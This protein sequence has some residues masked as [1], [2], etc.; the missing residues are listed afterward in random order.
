MH[1]FASRLRGFSRECSSTA[2]LAR[3]AK[4]ITVSV[5]VRGTLE[6]AVA[7]DALDT[8]FRTTVEQQYEK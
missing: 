6:S 1:L 5:M 3:F 4:R 2:I 8:L 7:P